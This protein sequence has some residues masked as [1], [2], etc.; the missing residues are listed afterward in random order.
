MNIKHFGFYT[1]HNLGLLLIKIYDMINDY[2]ETVNNKNP[3]DILQ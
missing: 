2:N 3:S 1:T